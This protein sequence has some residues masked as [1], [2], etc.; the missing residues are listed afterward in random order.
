MNTTP[1]ALRDL[2][3]DLVDKEQLHGLLVRGWR[4]LDSKDYD[5]WIGCWTDDAELAFGPW[6]RLRGAT[7]IKA[8]VI[9]AEDQYAAMFHYLLNTHF[10]VDG[11]HATG[12]GY[13][14]FVGVPDSARPGDHFDMGGSY[15]WDFVRTGQGWKVARQH[16]S[17]VWR[18][19]SDTLRS[20]S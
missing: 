20:F 14:L 16:L 2:V 15:D 13:M 9:Q 4:A 1:D 17:M 6:D 18:L 8:A 3:E 11:D 10:E 12:V 5:A 19:G 7:T